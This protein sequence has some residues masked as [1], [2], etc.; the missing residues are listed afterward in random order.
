[1]PSWPDNVKPVDPENYLGG[2]T[3]EMLFA[4]LN[5]YTTR[6]TVGTQHSYSNYG[7]ALLGELLARRAGRDYETALRERILS[8]LGM[9]RTV[10][11]L[12]PELRAAHAIG[13]T[14]RG[15]PVARPAVGSRGMLGSGSL[16]STVNDLAAF[17]QAQL[18]LRESPLANAMRMTQQ[19]DADRQLP[20]L[21]MGLGWHYTDFAD[22]HVVWHN[23]GT[24]GFRSF[25]GLDLARRRGVVVLSNTDND[26][27][28]LGFHLIRSDVPLHRPDPPR[29]F[30]AIAVD[31]GLLDEYVGTYRLTPEHPEFITFSREGNQLL[32]TN[33]RA[34]QKVFAESPTTFFTG[35]MEDWGTF[36]RDAAGR[37]DGM[38]WH[39][40][41]WQQHLKRIH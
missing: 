8:P 13:H 25:V 4:F 5:G 26:V 23:G 27:T 36:T 22:S 16:R 11:V 35:D 2:Y 17:V 20:L 34:T 7:M 33:R 30:I 1:L 19:T 21:D 24:P 12:T 18:G 6:R 28:N 10:I 9:E 29:E 3:N 15:N 39:R 37:V 32:A 14:T 31:A 40:E 38:T 41:N